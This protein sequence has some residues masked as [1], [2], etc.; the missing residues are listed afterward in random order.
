[1]VFEKL[2]PDDVRRHGLQRPFTSMQIICV[3]YTVVAFVLYF[4]FLVPNFNNFIKL[5][6]IPVSFIHIK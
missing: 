6:L 3:L 2:G 4:G 5:I 1:M